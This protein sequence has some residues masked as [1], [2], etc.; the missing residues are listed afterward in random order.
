MKLA[1]RKLKQNNGFA[2]SNPPKYSYSLFLVFL[3]SWIPILSAKIKP[4]Q[5]SVS[6]WYGL[7]FKLITKD[8]WDML[9]LLFLVLQNVIGE[10]ALGLVWL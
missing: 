4:L 8:S 7:C 10:A 3:L 5:C 6:I 2:A 9:G 1:T